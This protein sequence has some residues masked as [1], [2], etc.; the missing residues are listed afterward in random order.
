MHLTQALPF[1]E[2]LAKAGKPHGMMNKWWH[3]TLHSR[4][5][6]ARG[7]HIRT[8]GPVLEPHNFSFGFINKKKIN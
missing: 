1:H 6:A 5:R 2:G 3:S 4:P 8:F 7:P